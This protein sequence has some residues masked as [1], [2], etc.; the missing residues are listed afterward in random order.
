MPPRAVY[1]TSAA[2]VTARE[3]QGKVCTGCG[4]YKTLSA[5][6]RNRAARDGRTTRCADCMKAYT[7]RYDAARPEAKVARLRLWRARNAEHRRAYREGRRA[8]E[9]AAK[10]RR[11][12]EG[13]LRE[14]Q[15]AYARANRLLF[16][17]ASAKYLA[18]L[19]GNE[20][21]TVDYAA[22]LLERGATCHLCNEPI[23]PNEL[24]FDHV[25]PLKR[26]G[27]HTAA[28][29]RPAH[30]RCN[31]RKGDHLMEELAWHSG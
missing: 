2:L 3:G 14:R 9:A 27:T 20:A 5:F 18:R 30:G 12:H 29:I 23:L 31:R 15:A 22:I 1:T 11:Y 16:R 28:N 10:R 21:D 26:G 19:L 8:I 25:I 4:V 17:S 24:E 6:Y 7:A 13:D